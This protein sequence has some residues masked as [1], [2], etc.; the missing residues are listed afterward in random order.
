MISA[1]RLLYTTLIFMDTSRYAREINVQRESESSELHKL[2]GTALVLI[3]A[4][5]SEFDHPTSRPMSG[6][7]GKK[8]RCHQWLVSRHGVESILAQQQ[9]K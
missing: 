3:L 9:A 8:T 6:I 4:F 2:L 5:D 1:I 7:H